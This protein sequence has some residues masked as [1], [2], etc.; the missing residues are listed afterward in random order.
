MINNVRLVSGVQPSDSV[1]PI[2][3]S[4]LPDSFPVSVVR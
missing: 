2:D 3:V 1:T 4:V